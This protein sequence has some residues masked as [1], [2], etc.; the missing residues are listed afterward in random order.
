MIFLTI[1]IDNNR[2]ARGDIEYTS[3][4]ILGLT[5][6]DFMDEQD[7]P[8]G[9]IVLDHMGSDWLDAI[10]ECGI[11]CGQPEYIWELDE[12]DHD[13]VYMLEFEE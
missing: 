1:G 8:Q 4:T 9:A 2:D 13:R 12:P 5:V 3:I 6:G 10:E 11:E 7:T